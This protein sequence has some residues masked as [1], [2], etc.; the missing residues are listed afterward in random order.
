MPMK[1]G[2]L[3]GLFLKTARNFARLQD[4][5][6]RANTRR[7]VAQVKPAAKRAKSATAAA[8]RS[9]AGSGAKPRSA[10]TG[11]A[12]RGG[13]HAT[14]ITA[15]PGAGIWQPLQ[16]F[17]APGGRRLAYARYRPKGR[18]QGMPLVVMLHGCR[19][20]AAELALG[21]RMNLQA[22]RAGFV[23]LYPQQALARHSHRCW[24]WFQLHTGG[25]DDADAIAALI[26]AEIAR[27]GLDGRRVYLAGMSAGAGIAALIALRH[28]DL[29][30]AIALHS[31]VVTGGARTAVEGLN[32]MRRGTLRNPAA[33]VDAVAA[34]AVFHLG[35]PALVVHGLRD[36]AVSPRNAHQLVEQFRHINGAGHAE[37]SVRVLGK[38]TRREYRRTDVLCRRKPVVRLCEIPRVEHAWSGG[39][40]AIEYHADTGPDASVLAWQFFRRHRRP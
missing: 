13:A 23:V 10:R 40:P 16:Q 15:I 2:G 33:L 21:T 28:P 26:R 6:V 35:M 3:A 34:P 29:V 12:A 36:T 7:L 18:I 11:S 19:Q 38:G 8:A 5:L 14:P 37:T 30:S 27:E 32:V 9:L 39:D 24:R 1:R 20:N 22:D 4:K 17:S 31:G 25:Q